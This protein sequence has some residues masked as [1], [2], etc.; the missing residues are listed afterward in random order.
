MKSSLCAYALVCGVCVA[1]ASQAANASIMY[2]SA[3]RAPPLISGGLAGQDSWTVSSGTQ[4]AIQVGSAGTTLVNG[5]GPRE[6]LTH[7][8]TQITTGQTYYVGFDVTVSGGANTDN[9]T[10]FMA[11]NNGTSYATRMFVTSATGS[12]FTLGLSGNTNTVTAWGTGLTFGTSYRVVGSYTQGTNV[13]KLWVN[14]TSAASTSITS[15]AGAA[16]NINSILLRQDSGTSTELVSNMVV[17]TTFDEAAT[18][19]AI[20]APGAVALIGL[21]GLV[22]R[23]RRN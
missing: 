20:P 13:T 17:S 1:V 7:A 9:A 12:N 11:F 10:Y 18:F 16:T 22:A 23:R 6:D 15:T 5:S 2:S 8:L 3:L 4:N 21:A 14:P 19:P